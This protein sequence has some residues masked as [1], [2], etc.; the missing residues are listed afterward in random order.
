MCP[1]LQARRAYL[2]LPTSQSPIEISIHRAQ[3]L[4]LSDIHHWLSA[5]WAKAISLKPLT[6][7]RLINFSICLWS[8]S[9]RRITGV[10]RFTDYSSTPQFP[11]PGPPYVQAATDEIGNFVVACN[12]FFFAY[13][14]K[15][16][17]SITSHFMA[18]I[19][20]LFGATHFLRSPILRFSKCP[21]PGKINVPLA[22]LGV[23]CTL[24]NRSPRSWQIK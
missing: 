12:R 15:R 18:L 6:A 1:A 17:Y 10:A 19:N 3:H 13:E 22:T 4:L 8:E 20:F 11:A 24:F 9:R 21:S 14:T 7:R 16:R 2:P 5:S 23:C